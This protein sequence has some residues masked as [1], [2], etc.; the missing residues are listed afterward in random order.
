[1]PFIRNVYPLH[2]R[3]QQDNDPKHKANYALNFLRE[4]KVNYWPTTA[5]SPDMNPIEMLRNE[6]FPQK[7]N[8]ACK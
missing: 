4:N 5:E 7:K 3:F 8:K 2:H 1:M 6:K